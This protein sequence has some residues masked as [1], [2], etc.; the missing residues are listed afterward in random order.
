M[1]SR[2]G[3]NVIRNRYGGGML[4]E[5]IGAEGMMVWPFQRP[6]RDA[7]NDFDSTGRQWWNTGRD[8]CLAYR[9]DEAYASSY[10]DRWGAP[11]PP[12]VG[13]ISA[14][15][16]EGVREAWTDMAYVATARA[17]LSR[18]QF[19]DIER[20]I[21]LLPYSKQAWYGP[22]GVD[23]RLLDSIRGMIWNA[24]AGGGG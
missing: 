20:L 8:W 18:A 6:A 3:A 4:M 5:K 10:E 24:L 14:L 16:W 22:G 21:N 19:A 11:P 13:N 23:N 1:Y 9:R 7:F 12:G 2:Q 17:H 15:Q